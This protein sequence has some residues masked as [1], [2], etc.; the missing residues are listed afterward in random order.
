METKGN[1]YAVNLVEGESVELKSKNGRVEKL[2][3][4]ESMIIPAAAEEVEIKNLSNKK[5]KI[6]LVQV[7]EGI[8]KTLPVNNPND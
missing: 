6:V 2:S 8:G 3:Y 1:A 7:K 5:S 4:L